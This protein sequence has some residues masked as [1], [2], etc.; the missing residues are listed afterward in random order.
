MTGPEASSSAALAR[1][2]YK[3]VE[4]LH[5]AAYFAAEMGP[6][7][8]AAGV[9]GT[10]RGYF[11]VR[12]APMG[13]V[14]AEVVVA[15]FYNFSPT[16]VAEAIPSV[17]QETTPEAILAARL[18]G[19]D[20]VYRRVLGDAVVASAEMAEAAELAREATT[21]TSGVGR[22]LFAGHAGLPWPDAPHLQ[23]FHA[24]TLLREY[25]GDG[26]VAALALAGLD[27]IGALVTH[28]A[29]D[30]ASM[31]LPMVRATRGW[32]DE[33]WEAGKA[34]VQERGLVD[35]EG[36]ATAAGKALR[37]EIEQQTDEAA[38]APYV[39]LGPERVE[40]LRTLTRPWSKA[41]TADV[42]GGTR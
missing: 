4:P 22:A 15:T 26:H 8:A 36:K 20:A 5:T 13:Q 6:A 21:A 42:F 3:T 2:A 28:L 38:A 33:E 39:H 32:T 14:S 7:Y 30:E 37:E 35:A 23:L 12:S 25:R 1:K 41:I 24:Q 9:K 11:A 40:R 34:R 16:L 29:T 27:A 19:I 10:M 18:S 31:A 17:W